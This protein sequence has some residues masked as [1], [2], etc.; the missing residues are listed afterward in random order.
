MACEVAFLQNG[1]GLLFIASGLLTKEDIVDSKKRLLISRAPIKQCMYAIVDLS[2]VSSVEL[3]HADV[4]DQAVYDELIA[5]AIRPGAIIVIIASREPHYSLSRM[6][7][8][9]V[10]RTGWETMVFRSRETGLAWTRV[11]VR[12]KFGF[13]SI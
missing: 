5:M 11:R 3:S 6:W 2:A 1:A 9:F 10:K 4:R 12:E 7:E 13:D 8:T